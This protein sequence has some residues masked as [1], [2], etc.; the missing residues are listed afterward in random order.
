VSAVDATGLDVAG[1]LR[2]LAELGPP[3]ELRAQGA[4]LAASWLKLDRVLL[5]SIAGGMLRAEA[6]HLEAGDAAM[7]LSRL[8]EAPVALEYPLLEGEIMRRRRAQVVRAAADE[9]PSRRA[10]AEILGWT[11]YA[12]APVLLDGRAIG[13]LHGD[14]HGGAVDEADAAGLSAFAVC[15]AIVFER[16]VLRHRLRVQREQMRQV[17]SWADARTSELG[18]RGISLGDQD[19]GEEPP[20]GLRPAGGGQ[21]ALRNLLTARELEVLE[22]MVRGE[23]NA[24]IARDLV[25]SEGTI[26]FHVKNVLRKLH[27]SNRAEATSR[28]LRLTLNRGG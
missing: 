26:K 18:E 7:L 20:A 8:Q 4:G 6:L 23:T 10:F 1:I 5:T 19:A 21:D 14:R 15:F 13:F 11:E 2:R 12:T 3:S 25:L 28:Y 17:A 9:P 16:A 27:A 22:L 24:Q